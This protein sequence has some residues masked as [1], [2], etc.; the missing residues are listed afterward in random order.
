MEKKTQKPEDP[1]MKNLKNA[2]RTITA[3][4]I[5]FVIFNADSLIEYIL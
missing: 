4:V 2:L 5:L 3:A 1:T